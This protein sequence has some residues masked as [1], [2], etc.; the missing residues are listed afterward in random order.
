MPIKSA[1]RRTEQR[2]PRGLRPEDLGQVGE[3]VP[4]SPSQERGV[5]DCFLISY[6]TTP[7]TQGSKNTYVI[8][9]ENIDLRVSIESYEWEVFTDQNILY[10]PWQEPRSVIGPVRTEIGIF[11]YTPED[12]IPI[13][14]SVK[15]LDSVGAVLRS[16]QIKQQ[17]KGSH[18]ALE[19]LLK[20]SELQI[21]NEIR[22]YRASLGGHPD[23]S[24]EV[25]YDFLGYVYDAFDSSS[26]VYKVPIKFLTTIIYLQALRVPKERTTELAVSKQFRN[27]ELD[28]AAEELNG[29]YPSTFIIDIDNALGV[30]QIA[31]QSLAMYVLDPDTSKPYIEQ[32]E[33]PSEMDQ[34]IKTREDIT[35]AFLALDTDK[36]ADLYNRLRFPKCNIRMC[37]DL[38]NILKNR[39]KRYPHL[40]TSSFLDNQD[41]VK[42]IGTEFNIGAIDSDIRIAKSNSYG[43]DVW[44]VMNS[45]IIAIILGRYLQMY[46]SGRAYD[47]ESKPSKPVKQARVD[48][49]QAVLIITAPSRR[50][51]KSFRDINNPANTD[52]EM[53]TNDG[54]PLPVIEVKRSPPEYPDYDLVK[55]R[56]ESA[57]LN[58]N[59]GWV[60]TRIKDKFYARLDSICIEAGETDG[61]GQFN[62]QF[63]GYQ[64]LKIKTI[65]S[66][67][68]TLGYFDGETSWFLPPWGGWHIHMKP[69]N[70]MV[71]ESMLVSLIK[72]WKDYVYGGPPSYPEGYKLPKV[73]TL[74]EESSDKKI[75]CNTF[76]EPLVVEAWDKAHSPD[77]LW[78]NVLHDQAMILLRNVDAFTSVSVYHDRVIEVRKNPDDGSEFTITIKGTEVSVVAGAD[79]IA[80]ANN[81]ASALVGNSTLQGF[82]EASSRQKIKI[83]GSLKWAI[84]VIKSKDKN[85]ECDFEIRIDVASGKIVVSSDRL[86]AIPVDISTPNA[87]PP[88]WS[89]I[90]GWRSQEGGHNFF[91]VDIF[92]ETDP[93]RR[94]K[95]LTLESNNDENLKGPGF[96]TM[97][98]VSGETVTRNVTSGNIGQH[99]TS[100]GEIDPNHL[101]HWS[102]KVTATWEELKDNYL[103]RQDAENPVGIARLKLYDLK[104]VKPIP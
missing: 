1:V 80:T 27:S 95:V 83:D 23:T 50:C 91:I 67:E 13:V 60:I 56:R 76:V 4:T 79:K 35:N 66:P 11:E 78:N 17:V 81:I 16:L 5:Q 87:L 43:Q 55:V 37:F 3:I 24:R 38:L 36:K 89:V 85:R 44:R 12:T 26:N 48:L 49:Y 77:F 6:L 75:A 101:L 61:D 32:C 7:I 42:L 73:V 54:I 100:T 41:A 96:R 62:I 88:P 39:D 103:A 45:P 14:V 63:T 2:I 40:E 46:I 33:L 97:G 99:M 8:F 20:D 84:V 15:L 90:Q 34:R 30:C 74:T 59:E 29:E 31:P 72:D 64:L 21:G 58:Y 82:V 18:D 47:P 53:L 71:K 28:N 51:F 98:K 9:V 10:S 68:G 19:R 93:E 104:W 70:H 102:E 86:P 94:H 22:S 69:A 52:Y 92:H 57:K 65:K 25:Y